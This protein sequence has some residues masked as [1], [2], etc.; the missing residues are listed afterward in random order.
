M[1]WQKE[2]W[3][4]V[5]DLVCGVILLRRVSAVCAVG[6]II[7]ARSGCIF[8]LINAYVLLWNGDILVI[9]R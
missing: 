3:G 8:G 9:M 2:L 1:F 4:P 7:S 6:F 5:F